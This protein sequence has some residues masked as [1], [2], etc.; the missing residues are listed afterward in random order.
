MS[1]CIV[2]IF[3]YYIAITLPLYVGASF[4]LLTYVR[5]IDNNLKHAIQ[6]MMVIVLIIL[7]RRCKCEYLHI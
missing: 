4:I 1:S 5:V 3:N 6:F 7:M 2:N